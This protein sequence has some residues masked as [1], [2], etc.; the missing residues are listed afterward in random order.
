[1]PAIFGEKL[2]AV[3][4]VLIKATA[5]AI[6]RLTAC[7]HRKSA[8]RPIRR[9]TRKLNRKNGRAGRCLLFFLGLWSVD[10][11]A[12]RAAENVVRA[13]DDAF[14]ASV[15]EEQIGLYNPGS[16]RGFSPTSAGNVR[17]EGLF[18]DRQ[19]GF[20]AR[21]VG[22]SSIRAGLTAQGYLLPAPTG[23]ADFAL[24]RV[25]EQATQS[26]ILRMNEYG[27]YG[28]AAD[29]Q[30]R[31]AGG[32]LEST[33]GLAYDRFEIGDGTADEFASAGGAIRF[34]PREGAE[35][36]L[37]ADYGAILQEEISPRYF[38]ARGALPPRVPRREFVGQP[39]VGFE[40]DSH[41]LGFIA[42]YAFPAADFSLGL[43]RS[44]ATENGQAGQFFT[45]VK[46]DF[47]GRRLAFLGPPSDA[48]AD[49]LEARVSRVFGAGKRRHGV[50][51]N[52]RGRQRER[53][54]G[55]GVEIE[56]GEGRI[57][58]PAFVPR[59]EV[60]FGERRREKVEQ[61]TGG[62]SYDLR[63]RSVGQLNL[64]VQK[65][66]YER[67]LDDPGA[68]TLKSKA[69]PWLYN[70]SAALELRPWLAAYGG[71]VTGFEESPSAP[72]I[73]RNRNEAPPAI[74]TRQADA[75]L[76]VR[77]G[78]LTAVAGV[79]R[80]EKPFFGL[81]EGR[82]FVQRGTVSNR[83][84]ELSLAGAL[85]PEL[86]MVFGTVFLDATLTGAAVDEGALSAD[87]V[88]VVRRTSTLDLDYRPNW[89][90][91]WSFDLGI[92]GRGK[93]NGDESGQVSVPA[94]TLVNVGFRR[95]FVLGTQTLVVRG[96]VNNLFDT[97]GW[98]VSGNGAYVF[99]GPRAFELSLRIDI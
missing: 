26:L 67:R 18:I 14:G 16:V 79:F 22:R 97:F 75:G 1:M 55:G 69:N 95:Q 7:E 70:A 65:T 27:G 57:D 29:F 46:P 61:S 84:I 82:R 33:G 12:Q 52:V 66:D 98:S 72:T 83:G 44:V 45:N 20:S 76:R 32:K 96:R 38:P 3:W 43:F 68:G 54:F 89:A 64:G 86:H 47:T 39:W 17:I 49:S 51:L 63:W 23:I 8:L 15:G 36:T 62:L 59:P 13:A 80:I 24:R 5:V 99:Q 53:R 19:A 94:R 92:S 6:Y 58:T 78:E 10:A 11:P 48:A 50:T 28:F 37:F 91:G 56:L 71:Y 77:I 73:A 2:C 60:A 40:G 90:P 41:N 93:E 31:F 30:G 81:D 9:L 74:E 4:N 34:R 42:D 35:L 88:G 87:P 21:L 25:A 85:T